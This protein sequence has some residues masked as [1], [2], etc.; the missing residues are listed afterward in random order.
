MAN[1]PRFIIA[2]NPMAEP[3]AEYILHTQ[4]PRFLAKR[5][6]D[7]P[8]TDFEIVDDIDNM[9]VF[10]KNDSTKVAG[11]MRRLGDWYVAFI[12]W[13]EDNYNNNDEEN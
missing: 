1:Y 12:N 10:F 4:Q 7:N 8:T 3:D 5:V 6:H 9:A 2:E 13:E 11:L